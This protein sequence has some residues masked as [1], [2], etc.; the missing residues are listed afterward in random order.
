MSVD[1][2]P[3]PSPPP[4]LLPRVRA[5]DGIR[6]LAAVVV[7]VHHTFLVSPLLANPYQNPY[8]VRPGTIAW[9]ATYTPLHL[10]WDGTEA[11][12][13]FFV[14]SGFVLSLPLARTGIVRLANGRPTTSVVLSGSMCRCGRR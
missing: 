5:L 10:F 8:D 2:S 6:G 3:S 14:L 13:V 9:W 4:P 1:L 11:V 12:F 7:V